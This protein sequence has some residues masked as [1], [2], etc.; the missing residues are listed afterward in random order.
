MAERVKR[1]WPVLK[2]LKLSALTKK[3]RLQG[4]VMALEVDGPSLRVVLTNPR[5]SRLAVTRIATEKL[6]LAENADRSD[7]AVMGG[8]IAAALERLRLKP[9]A[10]VMGVPR[11]SVVLRTITLPVLT[12]VR[13]LA[14]LVH[15]QMGKDLPFRLEEAIIDFK[16]R[17]QLTP[18]PAPRPEAAEKSTETPAEP[19][20]EAA[21]PKL[22]VL[23][24]AVQRDVV[25]FYQKTAAVAGLK[26][27]ALG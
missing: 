12:D 19:K 6:E 9:G 8:A 26:L 7:P 24:A 17:R 14:S 25:E 10:V 16:V 27:V 15:F 21:V 13:E 3:R 18:P 4:P 1:G 22:E 23:V 20:P 5:G 11:A 2:N